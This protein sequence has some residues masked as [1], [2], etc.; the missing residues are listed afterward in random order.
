MS[1]S[2]LDLSMHPEIVTAWAAVAAISISLVSIILTVVTIAMQRAHNRKSVLPIGRI[3][4]GDYE[5]RISVKLGNDGVGP[6]II[7]DVVVTEKGRT[8]SALIDFMP[9]V[10]DSHTWTTFVRDIS[11]RAIPPQKEITLILLEGDPDDK[12]FIRVRQAVRKALSA[13]V[14]AVEYR[15]IYD[16][17]MP[18]TR[19]SLEW[20]GRTLVTQP[21]GPQVD[22]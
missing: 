11:D 16:E 20:F 22:Q 15:S 17:Q 9:T 2:L 5:N 19:R 18:T 4:V 13:L 6:M 1:N 3:T 10:P 14:I 21:Q 7:Q 12:G 8:G